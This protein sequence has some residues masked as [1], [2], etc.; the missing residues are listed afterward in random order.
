[1]KAPLKSFQSVQ[2]WAILIRTRAISIL[3]NKNV[4]KCKEN[5]KM[6]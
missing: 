1:M 5:F 4:E 3:V 6:Q 2:E